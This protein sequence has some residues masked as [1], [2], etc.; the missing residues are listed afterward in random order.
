MKR[1][2]LSLFITASTIFSAQAQIFAGVD[3]N[4]CDQQPVLLS[5]ITSR[6]TGQSVVL[7]DDWHSGV[8]DIGFTFN[9]Y[10]TNYTK[11]VL[12]S[13]NYITFDTTVANLYSNWTITAAAPNPAMI[14]NNSIMGPFQ[15]VNPMSVYPIYYGTYGTAPNRVFV[16]TFCELPM[17]SCTSL[18][19]SSQIKLFESTNFIENHIQSKPTCTS[20]NNGYAIQ[21]LIDAAGVN[22]TIV[23][24]RNFPNVWNAQAEGW[25]F[26]GIGP[27]M[28]LYDTITF[29]PT[30]V[31]NLAGASPVEWVDANGVVIGTGDT[32]TV[33]PPASTYYIARVLICGTQQYIQDTVN[34]NV[35]NIQPSFLTD[36]VQCFGDSNGFVQSYTAGGIGGLNYLWSNGATTDF[37]D[38]VSAGW[39][40][41]T[42][43]DA[44]NCVKIDSAFV[45]EAPEIE[46]P[47]IIMDDNCG[48]NTG[49]I[50]PAITGGV[51]PF[52]YLWSN[53]S[54][55]SVL[56][57]IGM[58][59]YNLQLTDQLGCVRSFD[60]T[61]NNID[62]DLIPDL[63]ML[64]EDA[65]DQGVGMIGMDVSG[66]NLPYTYLWSNGATTQN[67]TNLAA[68]TYFVTITDQYGCYALDTVIVPSI[69]GPTG[70]II[71]LDSATTAD[72]I[73]PFQDTTQGAVQ[74]YWYFGDGTTS[75][76]QNPNH[77]YA[78][79]GQYTVTL[80]VVDANGC[81][82]T[83]THRIWIVEEVYFYIPNSFTPNNDFLNDVLLPAVTGAADGTYS[84]RV[85]SRFGK[86]MFETND[87]SYGWDGTILGTDDLATQD[88]YVYVLEFKT[89]S[90][91]EIVERGTLT[92]LR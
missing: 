52:S 91:R 76:Q 54:T 74:W 89:P 82:D 40:F 65:C 27:S 48:S 67:I 90:G 4:Q 22:P 29:Q 85:Y 1:I 84:F 53:G 37:L 11:C 9:Y 60:L 33:N 19:F 10:G 6:M 30:V 92:L 59:T 88:V 18:L 51:A 17:F 36:S 57:G 77:P 73:V 7:S 43:T 64:V 69:P 66:G 42:I 38:N 41:V 24:G 28:Y 26:F 49:S 5:S 58:G 75:S 81:R 61:V 12:S 31:D 39:H 21:G 34:V 3:V 47:A 68:G 23:A 25:V 13:N 80:I 2:L 83:I 14:P 50:D 70:G 87:L 32:I 46:C 78:N 62:A 55:Q 35:S 20:W 79:I 16:V 15:D 8:I 63:V 72:L 56:T 71:A 86:L 44:V 45:G